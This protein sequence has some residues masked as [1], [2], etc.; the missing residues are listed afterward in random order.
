MRITPVVSDPKHTDCFVHIGKRTTKGFAGSLD[1]APRIFGQ[2][3]FDGH[4]WQI[5]HFVE[6]KDH[7]SFPAKAKTKATKPSR[8]TRKRKTDD[9][10]QYERFR[11]IARFGSSFRR[12]IR[13]LT[14]EARK[15]NL[16]LSCP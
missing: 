12:L 13:K 6:R 8:T 16:L 15:N 1:L 5:F 7:I 2:H 14:L 10:A 3:I 11:L 9:P 4:E